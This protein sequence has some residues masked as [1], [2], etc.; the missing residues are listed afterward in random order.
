ME[1]VNDHGAKGRTLVSGTRTLIMIAMVLG[2]ML[3][4]ATVWAVG[5]PGTAQAQLNQTAG[6][7]AAA[8]AVV[9]I[10]SVACAAGF[11][12]YIRSELYFGTTLP[13][14][15]ATTSD[16]WQHFLDTEITPR[17]PDGL[18]VLT[19]YGQ[20][21]NSQGVITKE[22]SIL[23]I[24]LYPV[25]TAQESSAK[26][27]QIRELYKEQFHQESVLRADDALPVCASF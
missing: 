26:L 6:T 19:G 9:S 11:D 3:G 12:P 17:F 14:G 7:P 4:G 5:S 16:D 20:W 18:T 13:E 1:T 24:I 15:T 2:L 22:G 8:T 23:L 10:P 25:E 27:D 21:R